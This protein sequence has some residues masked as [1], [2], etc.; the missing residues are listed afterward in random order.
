MAPLFFPRARVKLLFWWQ[1]LTYMQRHAAL[2]DGTTDKSDHR[3]L[4]K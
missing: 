1:E 4:N 2:M 3:Y